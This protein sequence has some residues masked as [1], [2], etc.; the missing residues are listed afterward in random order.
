MQNQDAAR[1]QDMDSLANKLVTGLNRTGEWLL[2]K[3]LTTAIS[4]GLGLVPWVG[5][6]LS[7]GFDFLTDA[8]TLNNIIPED[9]DPLS[10][11]WEENHHGH[12]RH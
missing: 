2:G 8:K 12:V 4:Q 5:R 6:P 3:A 1:M 11:E 10:W 7:Q 9:N